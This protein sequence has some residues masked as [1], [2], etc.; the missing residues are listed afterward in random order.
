[1]SSRKIVNVGRVKGSMVYTGEDF[2]SVQNPLENDLFLHS[3][4]YKF[5]QYQNNDWV[6]IVDLADYLTEEGL[7]SG[8]QAINVEGF[9]VGYSD[10]QYHVES[11]NEILTTKATYQMVK[12]KIGSLNNIIN[13]HDGIG[14]NAIEQE[15]NIAEGY[16]SQ[17]FGEGTKTTNHAAHTEGMNTLA[18]HACAHAEGNETIAS[19]FVSHAQ[20]NHSVASGETAFA[21]GFKTQALGTCSTTFGSETVADSKN[22]I[23]GGA[24]SHATG[25]V[26]F[27]FGDSAEANA[28]SSI[29]IGAHSI[30]DAP[31]AVSLGNSN[32]AMAQGTL[33]LGN[34]SVASVWEST[35]IGSDANAGGGFSVALG[36]GTV[37]SHTNQVAVGAYNTINNNNAFVVGGGTDDEHRKNLFE[38]RSDG[39]VKAYGTPSEDNDLVTRQ[40]VLSL[41]SEIST[42]NL[43][44][45]DQLPTSD[46]ST[47]TIYL[48]KVGTYGTNVYEE[49]IYTS[50]KGWEIIGTT[51]IDLSQY[52]TITYVDE[53]IERLIGSAPE[54]LDTLDEIANALKDNE[55]VVE[56]LNSAIISKADKKDIPTKLSQLEQD[57]K[58]DLNNYYTYQAQVDGGTYPRIMKYDDDTLYLFTDNAYSVSKDGGKTWSERVIICSPELDSTS[59]TQVDDVANAFGIISPNND[60]RVVVFYRA[61]NTENNYFTIRCRV[62]DTTGHNFGDYRILKT[63]YDGVWESFYYEGWLYYSWEHERLGAQSQYRSKITVNG[64]VVTIGDGKMAI[65]G[66]K[67]TNLDGNTISTSRIGMVGIS[68]L[69]N[70]GHIYVYENT[71]NKNASVPRPMVVQYAYGKNPSTDTI[72]LTKMGTLFIGDEGITM[73]APYV[74]TL[75][76]GRVVISFQTDQYY[77]GVTPENNLRKKQVVVYVSKREVKYSDELTADDFVRLNNYSYGEND[78]SVWG[79]VQNIDGRLYNT[80]NLGKNKSETEQLF[81]TNIV[82]QLSVDVVD[83]SQVVEKSIKNAITNV[84][85]TEV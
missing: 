50:V 14:K 56:A 60:G 73:G 1:M 69:K 36:H 81:V 61:N 85:N 9:S 53:K 65:D 19:G 24:K 8:D 16:F 54:T 71:V 17:A 4:Q 33:A 27:A 75:D 37:T 82:K 70:G 26:S 42:L 79:C 76:D 46:I 78:Y 66:R 25:D 22:S 57:I 30:A 39:R 68:Q 10:G 80:F 72:G 34:R 18:S 38:V 49:W 23:A 28:Y 12:E 15:G 44:I 64:E 48:K 77:E 21:T 47:T 20:G 35:A 13:L 55:D 41:L 62:S 3:K 2:S 43:Q 52:A 63:N 67:S 32:N 51:E 58:L 84:L 40:H 7:L 45:V 11:D 59:S 74:T 31:H 83:Y 5:Y 29:A 6:L